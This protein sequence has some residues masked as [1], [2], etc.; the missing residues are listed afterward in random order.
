M[1]TL[2]VEAEGLAFMGSGGGVLVLWEAFAAVWATRVF[3]FV[4]ADVCPVTD[5]VAV[6]TLFASRALG[7]DPECSTVHVGRH[8]VEVGRLLR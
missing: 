1:F 7:V 5:D 6:G 3:T 8:S 2:A 4:G